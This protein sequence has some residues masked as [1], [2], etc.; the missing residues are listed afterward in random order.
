MITMERASTG[1]Q[2]TLA[3]DAWEGPA[4]AEDLAL[5]EGVR[6]AVLDIGCGPGRIAAALA[7]SGLPSLGIDVSP[8][9]L[10]TASSL[11]AIVL[12][13]SVFDP[14]PGEGRWASVLLLDGNIGIGGDHPIRVQSMTT[15]DTMD[16]A[17]TVA[18]SIR[19]IEAG[20]ELIKLPE[21]VNLICVDIDAMPIIA[22]A[23]SDS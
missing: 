21:S 10:T 19:M 13:R 23:S 5:L 17:G 7:Q 18:Q 12:E 9:A 14:L 11:G 22:A 15:T 2:Q 16:T 8:S 3:I 20:C 4:T 1:D 6:P